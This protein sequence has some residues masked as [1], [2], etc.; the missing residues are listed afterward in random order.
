MTASMTNRLAPQP[1]EVIKRDERFSFTWN[2]AD[3][4]AFAGDTIASALAACGVRVFSRSYKY[5]RPH[6]IL[7]ADYLDPCCTVQ[8]GDEPNVRG[9]HR[10]AKDGMDVRAQNA[11]PSLRFDLKSVNRLMAR[12]MGPGFYYKTFMWPRR[13][14]PFYERILR[15]FIAG[16][17]IDPQAE[18]GYYDKRYAHPDVLVAGGGPAGMAAAVA[19]ANAGAQVMLVEEGHQLGGHLRWGDKTQLRLLDQLRNEVQA[20]A[21][22]EVLTDSVVTGRYDGNWIAVV[23]RN[24]PGVIERLIKARAKALIVAPGL[25]ERPYVFEGNDLP[26]VMLSGAVRRLINLYAVSPGSRAVVFTANEEGDRAAVDLRRANVEVVAVVDARRGDSIVRAYGRS[27][28]RGVELANEVRVD[29]D[30]LVIAAGW[31]APGLLLNM[32]GDRP[33]YEAAAA[34]FFPGGKVPDDVFATGGLAGDGSTQ[35]LI[36]HAQAVGQAAAARAG[37]GSRSAIPQL[38]IHSHPPLFRNQTHGTVDWCE[39]VTSADLCS[40]VKEGYD[41]IE[42]VKRYTT[43]TM[44]PTQGKLE[45]IN[46]MAIVAEMLGQTMEETGTTVWRPPYAPITLGGLAGQRMEPMQVSPMQPWHEAHKA[47]PLVAGRWIRPEHYGDPQAE[48]ANTRT[49]VGIIDVTPLGKYLLHGPDTVKLLNLL[50]VNDWSAL[51]SGSA[52]YGLMC[53]EDGVVFDDGVTAR[54]ADDEYFMTTT[55]SGAAAVGQWIESWLQGSSDNWRIHVV[56]ATD[57]F[58]SMNVA[59]PKSAELLQRLTQ[60]VDLH[61]SAFPY[62]GARNGRVAGVDGCYLLRLGFTGELSYE[63]HVP[64]SYGLYVWETLIEC[65]HDLGIKP[66]GIEAQRVMR[67]EKGHVIVGQDTDGLTQALSLGLKKFV[68]FAKSDFVGKPELQWQT[69][70]NDYPRLIGLWPSDPGLVPPEASLIVKDST[71]VGRITSSRMSPTLQR[72]ICMALLREDLSRAGTSLEIRLPD[73]RLVAAQVAERR[74]HFDPQGT[75]LRG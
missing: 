12:F 1:G 38:A 75:R 25:I 10:L 34:R 53:G 11:W 48:V 14:W 45:T 19:A 41:S 57:A 9:A 74:V 29:C 62:M 73:G 43:S 26:G 31:T 47:T 35:E 33:R 67:L 22:I 16:G 44:G 18:H 15:R 3:F 17:E 42:L 32:A 40:A 55:S 6:G 54:I 52:Q 4:P 50:Y 66:F 36:G 30:L 8:V 39:D 21:E 61:T 72:S 58:A 24:L 69:E 70:R 60:E 23:Q 27:K 20:R 49:N 2:G 51:A 71:I 56:S 7:T 28:V 5:H 65:G 68:K 46:T 13:W 64:A 59:G 37:Y 63:L